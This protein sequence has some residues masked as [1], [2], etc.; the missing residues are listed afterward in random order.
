MTT[1]QAI[2]PDSM[3][4]NVTNRYKLVYLGWWNLRH[5]LHYQSKQR[6]DAIS[7]INSLKRILQEV[8]GKTTED[9]KKNAFSYENPTLQVDLSY[10][11]VPI[12]VDPGSRHRQSGETTLNCCGWCNYCTT[13]T[14]IPVCGN[15]KITGWCNIEQKPVQF[16]TKC[17]V[18]NATNKHL[19]ECAKRIKR[20]IK[21]AE[22]KKIQAA[23]YTECIIKAMQKS[24]SKPPFA[25]WRPSDYY[26]IDQD[27]VCFFP[28]KGI[29]AITII[30]NTSDG[31]IFTVPQFGNQEQ[32]LRYV[33][34][35]N[36]MGKWEFE[37][38]KQHPKYRAL[39]LETSN[40]SDKMAAA[41]AAIE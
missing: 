26:S 23:K 15:C 10:S 35:P 14:T 13:V 18:K 34:D 8:D 17:L 29:V 25:D 20:D 24:E 2:I 11:G 5:V 21:E 22:I 19:R 32:R 9:V 4:I 6:R 36:I 33:H 31:I 16:D 37:Y 3:G 7:T 38:L 30:D 27:M 28:E 1:I 39:W 12:P 41:F 40:A